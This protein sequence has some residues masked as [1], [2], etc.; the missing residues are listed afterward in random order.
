MT[1]IENGII[2]NTTNQRLRELEEQQAKLEQEIIIER[3]KCTIT[4]PEQ[5]IREFYQ[6]ALRLDPQMLINY[7]VREIILFDDKMEIH[8]NS[9]LRTSPDD[10]QGFSFYSF[11]IKNGVFKIVVYFKV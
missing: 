4:I 5:T 1:A 2:T 3:T 6:E 8:F 9:P 11:Q 10:D 7:F